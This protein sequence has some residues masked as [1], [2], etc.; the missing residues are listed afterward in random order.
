MKKRILGI[1][2]VAILVAMAFTSVVSAAG[3]AATPATVKE[4]DNVAVKVTTSQKVYG[5]E[6]T[7]TYD[8]DKFEYVSTDNAAAIVNANTAG[9]LKISLAQASELDSMTLNFKAKAEG[10]AN[11][12]VASSA[13]FFDKEGATMADEKLT[14]ATASVTVEKTTTEEPKDDE[15]D[16][17]TTT[18]STDDEKPTSIP[19]AGTNTV[20]YVVAGIAIIAVAA[21]VVSRKK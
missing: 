1:M 3:V 16:N 13:S 20:V 21:M 14:T 4:G 5:M 19:Q 2:V 7:L 6:F 9:T 15:K 18:P 11:F 17:N 10:T 8:A 12:E